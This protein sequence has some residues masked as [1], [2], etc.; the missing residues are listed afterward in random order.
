MD[1]ELSVVPFKYKHLPLLLEMLKDRN[2]LG[3]NTV[4]MKTLPKIGYICLMNKQPIAAGF[5][6]R[7]EGGYAQMDG[8]TS[9]PFYGSKIRHEGIKLVVDLLIKDAKSLKLNGILAFTDDAGVLIR[10]QNL[11]FVKVNQS[12]IALNVTKSST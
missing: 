8:L 7:V 11:G 3:I 1:N 6:R 12:L 2:Y 9:N 5:L 4:S 10:A